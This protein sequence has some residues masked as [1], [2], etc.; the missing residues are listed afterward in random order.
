MALTNKDVQLPVEFAK[1]IIKGVQ[2]RS[3]ALELGR[4]LP[5]MVGKTYKL[6]VLTA[7][8]KA[9]W[10]KN[11]Q[12]PANTEGAEI[13][14]KPISQIAW[15]GVDLTAETIACIVPVSEETL[16]D[17]EDYGVSVVPTIYEDVIGAFQQVLDA[18]AFFGTDS[19]WSGFNGIVAGATSAGA[20]V[21][22]DGQSGTSFYNA[23]S[24]AMEKVETSGYFPTAI[25]GAPSL[26]GAFRN[27]ITTL[28][29]VAGDQ[30][31]IGGLDRHYDM[32]G[33]FDSSTAF[34]IVGDFKYLVYAFREEISMKLLTEATIDD[35][36]TGSKLYNLAQQ[37]MVAFRFKMRL[38][39]A[40]PNPVNRVSGVASGNVIKKGAGAYPFA[41]ITKSAGGSN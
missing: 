4:R 40:L 17:T 29:V 9:G 18:T 1:E 13:N 24:E 32:T 2:G 28:G 31:E 23:V 38:G 39:M 19:P 22:W 37:D 5:N 10:V 34:A 20:V 26:R 8:A 12:S 15:E 30:G 7:L 41:I 3:K 14:R 35:P 25:L 36:A 33:G 11:T 21:A 16:A 27:T 6:N